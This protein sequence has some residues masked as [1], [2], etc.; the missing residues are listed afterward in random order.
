VKVVLHLSVETAGLS[1]K[2][3]EGSHYVSG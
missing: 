1:R 3:G 2:F